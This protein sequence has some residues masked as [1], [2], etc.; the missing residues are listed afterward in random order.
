MGGG[1]PTVRIQQYTHDYVGELVI[2]QILLMMY[3]LTQGAPPIVQQPAGRKVVRASDPISS[4]FSYVRTCHNYVRCYSAVSRRRFPVILLTS[5]CQNVV[6]DA[7]LSNGMWL[8]T[9]VKYSSQA[10]Q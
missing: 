5:G 7:L 1:N 6:G 10:L 3:V 2:R 8:V 9:H 4:P